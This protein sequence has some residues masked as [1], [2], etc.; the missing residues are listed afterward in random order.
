MSACLC[1]A[2]NLCGLH[3]FEGFVEGHKFANLHL[4]GLGGDGAV[5]I[6]HTA[7]CAFGEMVFPT[8]VLV[9]SFAC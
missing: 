3:K 1:S 6:W 2:A 7:V 5:T 9:L 8:R 4:H